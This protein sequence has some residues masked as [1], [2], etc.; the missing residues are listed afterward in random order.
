MNNVD[1]KDIP[2]FTLSTEEK[3][4]I[5]IAANDD[6]TK[7][8][9]NNLEELHEKELKEKLKEGEIID[10]FPTEQNLVVE[11]LQEYW[12]EATERYQQVK[13]IRNIVDNVQNDP[14]SKWFFVNVEKF[15]EAGRL[16]WLYQQIKRLEHMKLI[17]ERRRVEALL[18]FT[19]FETKEER[20]R[21]NITK[22]F[23]KEGLLL[24]I[25]SLDGIKLKGHGNRYSGLCPFHEEKTGSFYIYHD[26]W[27][28][29]YGCQAH[30]NFIDY[31]M[32]TRHIEFKEALKQADGY[33]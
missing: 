9:F 27:Y 25:A 21:Y 12:D 11:K 32:K 24:E 22:M 8:Y 20:K 15:K 31:L 33:L 13:K 3:E 1:Q 28:H 26:N 10:A 4:R 18:T 17:Y 23:A 19:K 5:K 14:F 16:K 7:D 29:C 6:E 2:D 30:G